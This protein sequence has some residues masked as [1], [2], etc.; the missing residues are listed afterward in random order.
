MWGCL[1]SRSFPFSTG[2]QDL[3]ISINF[4][5]NSKKLNENVIYEV[6]WAGA[7]AIFM[8]FSQHNLF[9]KIVDIVITKTRIELKQTETILKEPKRPKTS[10]KDPKVLWNNPKLTK[11]SKLRKSGILA[12]IFP[13]ANPNT[14]FWAFWAKKYQLSNFN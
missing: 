9:I 13:I 14:Q 11:I 8:T 10:Q 6:Y 5:F 2:K 4:V 12:F 1:H 7:K 3:H